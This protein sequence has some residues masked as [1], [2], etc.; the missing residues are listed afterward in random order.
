VRQQ[1]LDRF[2]GVCAGVDHDAEPC[3]RVGGGRGEG[4]E[5]CEVVCIGYRMRIFAAG[6]GP[7]FA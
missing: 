1:A 7:G 2:S 4:E 5:T 3:W 6:E